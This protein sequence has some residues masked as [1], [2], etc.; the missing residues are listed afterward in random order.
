MGDDRNVMY[1]GWR[2]DGGHS[3]ER[4]QIADAF[5]NHAFADAIRVVKCPCSTCRNGQYLHK[6][7]IE[8][9]LCKNGFMPN[10]LVWQS[11]VRGETLMSRIK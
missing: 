8:V 9:H 6:D 3:R 2:S 10:Y 5:L 1:E 11:V 7:K 4:G